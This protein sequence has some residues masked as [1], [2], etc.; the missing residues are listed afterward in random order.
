M[1]IR[2]RSTVVGTELKTGDKVWTLQLNG[3]RLEQVV[4]LG[5][6]VIE[7][8]TTILLDPSLLA[9]LPV[10]DLWI[11]KLRPGKALAELRD[12]LTLT[13][14]AK[15]NEKVRDRIL[16]RFSPKAGPVLADGG[17]WVPGLAAQLT[18]AEWKDLLS[19]EFK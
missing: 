4:P 19:R 5:G 17:R 12:R 11:V 16:A 8:N 6:T 2:D 13:T 7:V 14:F 1:C 3:R 18:D 9:R 10:K 15:W